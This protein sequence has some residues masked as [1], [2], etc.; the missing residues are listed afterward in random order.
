MG[1][2]N[3]SINSDEACDVVVGEEVVGE[4]VVG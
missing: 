2:E 4:E 3:Y 1:G